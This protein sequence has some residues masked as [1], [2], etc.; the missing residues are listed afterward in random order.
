[1]TVV[2]L[3]SAAP[4]LSPSRAALV[5]AH[6]AV[7]AAQEAFDA[8]RLSGREGRVNRDKKRPLDLDQC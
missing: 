3:K 6:A 8:G 2:A 5:A 1:M 7:R 4:S